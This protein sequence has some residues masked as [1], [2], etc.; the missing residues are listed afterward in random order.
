[1]ENVQKQKTSRY[2][3]GSSWASLETACQLIAVNIVSQNSQSLGYLISPFRKDVGRA[4]T[5]KSVFLFTIK[6]LPQGTSTPPT[7]KAGLKNTVLSTHS[8]RNTH[9]K[10]LCSKLVTERFIYFFDKMKTVGFWQPNFLETEFFPAIFHWGE[11][12][13]SSTLMTVKPFL[14]NVTGP[15]GESMVSSCVSR[16]LSEHSSHTPPF[17][18]VHI[19]WQNRTGC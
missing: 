2:T 19:I 15:W 12:P 1:M 9:K 7:V 10:C 8:K 16:V 18:L 13:K 14:I 5:Q 4:R 11:K 17:S 3:H 6:P